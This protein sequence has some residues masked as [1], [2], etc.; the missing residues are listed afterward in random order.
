[1]ELTELTFSVG[2]GHIGK[3]VR[4]DHIVNAQIPNL[5]ITAQSNHQIRDDIK[6]DKYF[7]E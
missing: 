5:A 4:M 7:L 2:A 3:I 1:M 6:Y